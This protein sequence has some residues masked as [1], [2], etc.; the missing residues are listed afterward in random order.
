MAEPLHHLLD[1]KTP[2]KWD[3]TAAAFAVV[4]NLFISDAVLVQYDSS[5]HLSLACDASPYGMGTILSHILPNRSE[6][7][8]AYY[9]R[10]LSAL[11][12]NYCQLEWEALAVVSS[13]KHFHD[14]LY[15]HSFQLITDHKPLLGLLAN[16]RQTPAMISP[17]CPA[18]QNF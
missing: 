7:L 18:D 1:A 2:W 17:A 5:L 13:V 12:R 4:K 14:Y 15:G 10:M 3:K 11:E 9:S 6:A 8:I 16:D